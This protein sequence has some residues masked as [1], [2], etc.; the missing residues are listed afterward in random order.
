MTKEQEW[1]QSFIQNLDREVKGISP[2]LF[3]VSNY[4]LPYAYEIAQYKN[5][6]IEDWNDLKYETDILIYEQSEESKEN[7]KPRIIIEGKL[8]KITTHD[9]IT[10]SQ[11]AETH[12]NVHPYL[13]YGILIGN[14]IHYPLP[15]R[16]FRHGQNFDFMLSWTDLK[17]HPEEWQ[18][19]KE[20][21]ELEYQASLDTEEFLFNSRKPDRKH[22]TVMHK[23]LKLK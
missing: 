15:G 2:K 16:L 14:R 19:L 4:K 13:R 11:K 9:A 22:Y 17:P 10:Y 1:I 21:I 20:I 6:E 8:R 12:K 7:W 18:N 5:E 23:Q 3:A